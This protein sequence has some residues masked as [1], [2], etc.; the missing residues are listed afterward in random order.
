[1]KAMVSSNF[2]QQ[3]TIYQTFRSGL[4]N[5][6]AL[7]DEMLSAIALLISEYDPTIRE[8]RFIVG[9]TVERI[10][11]AAMRGVGIPA[12]SRGLEADEEDIMV[13]DAQ[14]SVKSSF[15]KQRSAIRLINT[16][17]DSPT[18]WK[19]PTIFILG[20]RGIGYADPGL[21]PGVAEKKRDAVVLSRG[22]L[23]AMHDANPQWLMKCAVPVKPSDT[24]QRRAASEAVALEIIQRTAAGKPLFP[25]LRQHL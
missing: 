14:I 8:N 22:P 3:R 1:M 19:A 9:G 23:D 18:L 4:D 16:L 25:N 20:D 15:T 21:L 12:R 13:G 10:V 17:G 24:S 11:A 6:A 5:N 7:L 2:T